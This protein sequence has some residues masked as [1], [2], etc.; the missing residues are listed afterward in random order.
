MTPTPDI[1]LHIG[2]AAGREFYT[3]EKG[4]H[5]RGYGVIPDVDEEKFE[6]EEAEERWPGKK[7]PEQ[8]GTGFDTGDVL[9][10]W[11]QELGHPSR[12][13]SVPVNGVDGEAGHSSK[14][15]KESSNGHAQEVLRELNGNGHTERKTPDVRLSPDAGNYMCGFIYY[16]SL[17]HY[18][19]LDSSHLP[20][21]FLHVPDLSSSKEKLDTGREVAIALIRALV[22]SR[23]KVGVPGNGTS[24]GIAKPEIGKRSGARAGTD[25]NFSA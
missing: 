24:N 21:A 5:G 3:L 7:F 4:A 1:I 22:E 13:N 2:L 12:M 11:Q 9:G 17:A 18:Y 8:L 6:D 25:V 16:N 15:S 23:K 20:V 14:I 10:R 19:S